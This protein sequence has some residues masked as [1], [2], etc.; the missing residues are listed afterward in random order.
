M[1]TDFENWKKLVEG[2]KIM[3][4]ELKLPG[5]LYF[6]FDTGM[7]CYVFSEKPLEFD[8]NWLEG[9]KFPSDKSLGIHVKKIK[10]V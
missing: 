3:R 9:Y 7:V 1:E 10:G 6:E 5:S 2:A 4:V 8:Y